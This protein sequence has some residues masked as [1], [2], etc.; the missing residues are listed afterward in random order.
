M[1]PCNLN[2]HAVDHDG[3]CLLVPFLGEFHERQDP[4]SGAGDLLIRRPVLA[5]EL[6]HGP[7]RLRLKRVWKTHDH[8]L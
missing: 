4:L 5:L 6:A 8:F 1:R 3:R 2:L 7:G